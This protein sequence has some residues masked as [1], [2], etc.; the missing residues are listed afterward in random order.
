MAERKIVPIAC[1]L[2]ATD[3]ADRT[4]EWAE[5]VARADERIRT[6]DGVRLRFPAEPALAARLA[7][8]AAKEADC[9]AFFDFSLS[10]AHGET[11][12]EVTAPPDG[13]PILTSLFA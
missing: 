9:C 13:Q 8:L 7:E 10:L 2:E 5:V 4:G 1:T 12:L 11:W 6:D 3:A